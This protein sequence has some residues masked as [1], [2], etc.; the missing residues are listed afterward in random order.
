MI[1]C[2]GMLRGGR[3]VAQLNLPVDFEAE[4]E[5][6]LADL[7]AQLPEFGGMADVCGERVLLMMSPADFV[8]IYTRELH[9]SASDHAQLSL[10]ATM[11]TEVEPD[12]ACTRLETT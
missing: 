7:Q 8:W 9:W 3:G 5:A 10:L 2:K 6:V 1:A 4:A 12:N 11:A